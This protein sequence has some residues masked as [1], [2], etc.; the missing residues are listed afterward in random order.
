[1][2]PWMDRPESDENGCIRFLNGYNGVWTIDHDDGS[3]FFNDTHN[4]MLWGG[5]KNYVRVPHHTRT[6]VCHDEYPHTLCLLS[7]TCSC[8]RRG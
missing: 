7:C 8:G 5:C 1:M 4:L 3:Q 6:D 2:E